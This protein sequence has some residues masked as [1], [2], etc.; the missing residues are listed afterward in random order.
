MQKDKRI[1]G[2]GG[3]E[4]KG[5]RGKREKGKRGEI[6]GSC[7][8]F[9]FA[10][11]FCLTVSGCA[12]ATTTSSRPAASVST[13][14]PV[15]APAPL[16]AG[17]KTVVVS[18]FEGGSIPPRPE[19]QFWGSALANLLIADLRA[20]D[21]L[22]VIDRHLLAAVLQEQGLSA[23]D[24]ADPATRLRIGNILSAH[25]F[26]FGTY[27]L[28][29][30][31]A[32]FVARMDDVETGQ[33]VKTGQVSGTAAEMRLLSRKLSIEFLRGLDSRLADQEETK[34]A[35]GGGPPLEAVRYF[36]EGLDYESRGMYD[37]A[38]EMYTKALT[39]H[40]QYQEAREHLEKASEKM[41]R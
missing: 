6:Q 41:V 3:Q 7:W 32:L 23:G 15:S 39:V 16:L 28:L 30:D 19:T 2:T 13:P 33:V 26:I 21:S 9:L 5:K 14:A 4:E 29:G 25:F 12:A 31:S 18:D 27:T 37:Q 24:L 36:S 17:R 10:L 38:V 22:R 20:S 8:A 11:L 35:Q 34:I 1:Q 40:P